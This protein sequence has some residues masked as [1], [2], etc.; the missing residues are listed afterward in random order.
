MEK[1]YVGAT[2]KS[3]KVNGTEGTPVDPQ[4]LL[5]KVVVQV[6]THQY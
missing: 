5:T 1:K 2:K 4:G 3:K 6:R